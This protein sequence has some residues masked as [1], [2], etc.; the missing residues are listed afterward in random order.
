LYAIAVSCQHIED[1]VD[2]IVDRLY[3]VLEEQSY[4]Y[5]TDIFDE[6]LG[7]TQV[8]ITE[9]GIFVYRENLEPE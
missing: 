7:K 1:Q 2:E 9:D 5:C 6:K 3:D 8:Q 4:R